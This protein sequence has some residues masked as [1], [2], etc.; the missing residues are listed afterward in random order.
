MNKFLFDGTTPVKMTYIQYVV[1]SA[2]GCRQS[3]TKCPYMHSDLMLTFIHWPWVCP[4]LHVNPTRFLPELVPNKPRMMRNSVEYFPPLS[5]HL[6]RVYSAHTLTAN[7]VS[8][9][10]SFLHCAMVKTPSTD[11]AA[12]FPN[13]P[14]FGPPHYPYHKSTLATN[15]ITIIQ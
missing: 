3:P 11:C 15:N 10:L 4:Q 9:F 7:V 12:S 2:S 13:V 8:D 5:L 1:L 6:T 14:T